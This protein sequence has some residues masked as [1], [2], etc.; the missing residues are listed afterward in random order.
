M[1]ENRGD[2]KE[3]VVLVKGQLDHHNGDMVG[4]VFGPTPR[5]YAVKVNKKVA[6]LALR[7]ALSFHANNNT[8]VVR[9]TTLQLCKDK[10]ILQHY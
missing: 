5:S 7:S 2:K 1:A 4:R 10:K 6:Q 9:A 8:L 3:L